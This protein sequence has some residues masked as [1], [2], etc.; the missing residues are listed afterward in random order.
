VPE[1][2][3]CEQFQLHSFR[4]YYASELSKRG[5][6]I[7]TIMAQLGHADLATTMRYL[8]LMQTTETKALLDAVQW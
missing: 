5:I 7:R 8:G 4:R 3:E 6:P 1:R 2:E